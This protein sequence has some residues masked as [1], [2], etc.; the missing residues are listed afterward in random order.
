MMAGD[1]KLGATI[2]SVTAVLLMASPSAAFA[3][4]RAHASSGHHRSWGVRRGAIGPSRR[5]TTLFGR[6]GHRVHR[7]NR[8]GYSVSGPRHS[9]RRS[10][11]RRFGRGGG[12]AIVGRSCFGTVGLYTGLRGYGAPVSHWRSYRGRRVYSYAGAPFS[13]Y[14]APVSIGHSLRYVNRRATSVPPGITVASTAYDRPDTEGL[15]RRTWESWEADA[16]P[17]RAANLK[18]IGEAQAPSSFERGAD[19][20][21]TEVEW[22]RR[23][24]VALGR[25]DKA[26][27]TGRYAEARAEYVRALVLADED[28][29]VRIALG[30]SEFALGRFEDASRAIRE[31]VVRMPRLARSSLDL[32]G[33][34]GRPEALRRDFAAH[35]AALETHVETHG[36]DA[37]ARFLLGFIRY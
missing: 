2:W 24:G 11:R 20:G 6:G 10:V 17:A 28:A 18:K 31:G 36:D 25:G 29:G 3:G 35:L 21:G 8:H 33:G 13:E 32:R 14:Y 27:E 34:Y 9:G 23:V 16:I 4:G 15:A 26:F 30:I 22:A 12:R 1:R 37:G 19:D 7:G 5:V